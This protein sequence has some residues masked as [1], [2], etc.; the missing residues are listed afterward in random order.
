MTAL[1]VES[2]SCSITSLACRSFNASAVLTPSRTLLLSDASLYS[3]LKTLTR[4]LACS[5]S[6]LSCATVLA[7]EDT[8]SARSLSLYACCTARKHAKPIVP[9]VR[10][11]NLWSVVT[12]CL[13]TAT[14]L[15][16]SAA[17]FSISLAASLTSFPASCL[18]ISSSRK[19]STFWIGGRNPDNLNRSLF[20]SRSVSI[21]SFSVRG[22]VSTTRPKNTF[23]A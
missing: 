7:L 5:L 17:F 15:G 1:A 21:G 22:C 9:W 19:G 6:S 3:C 11:N 20:G 14:F 10:I 13:L 2:R 8:A 4:S 16:S 12:V 18:E 23:T